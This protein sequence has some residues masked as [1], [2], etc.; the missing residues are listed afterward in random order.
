MVS[1]HV[2]GLN[3]GFQGLREDLPPQFYQKFDRIFLS[4]LN[5]E[6]ID[7]NRDLIQTHAP[8]VPV[9][10]TPA[11][12]AGHPQPM[13]LPQ[14]S[15][16]TMALDHPRA[17]TQ[18]MTQSQHR[19]PTTLHLIGRS[20]EQHAAPFALIAGVE[21]EDTSSR[22]LVSSLLTAFETISPDVA[23]RVNGSSAAFRGRGTGLLV[24]RPFR[25]QVSHTHARHLLE[26]ARD[27]ADK[28]LAPLSILQGPVAAPLAVIPQANVPTF[29]DQRQQA[30]EISGTITPT[31][32]QA[33]PITG[34][35][36]V[37]AFV[38]VGAG[39][40]SFQEITITSTGR[41]FVS[42]AFELKRPV[43]PTPR[44]TERARFTD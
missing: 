35:R 22:S 16:L 32:L 34:A 13:D 37:V 40:V 3:R 19:G 7:L 11:P 43:T 1:W 29:R 8:L 41:R 14:G 4:D 44:P 28:T 21:H 6:R 17:I 26:V 38:S 42:G 31:H 12:A 5:P 2:G 24:T 18:T 10:G 36:I 20:A 39:V 15:V 33:D 23:D 30:L 25:K 27:P 9:R